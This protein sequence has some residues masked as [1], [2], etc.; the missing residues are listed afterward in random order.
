MPV[1]AATRIL[2][3]RAA[4]FGFNLL[5]PLIF[6]Q[7]SLPM[8]R[9]RRHHGMPSLGFDLRSVFTEADLTLFADVPEMV[10]TLRV[11]Q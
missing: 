1:H 6:A 2:G 9:L 7:H 11:G 5:R 10:P 8:H 4:N 3:F